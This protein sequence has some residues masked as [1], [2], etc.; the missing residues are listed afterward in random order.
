M[1][2]VS[3]ERATALSDG[4]AVADYF[5]IIWMWRISDLR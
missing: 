5:I 2:K 4:I 1:A 3:Y